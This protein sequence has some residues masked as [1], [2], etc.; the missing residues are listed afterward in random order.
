MT[1]EEFETRF[2]AHQSRLTVMATHFP[3][4]KREAYLS[5]LAQSYEYV[6]YSTRILALTAGKFPIDKNAF[7]TRFI[8][9][10]AEERGHDRLL[11]NDANFLDHHLPELPV[12]PEAEAFHKSLYFWI[13]QDN[14]MVILGW[15]F[16]LEG[17]AVLNA[18]GIYERVVA[19]HGKRAASFLHVHSAEDPDHLEKAFAAVR[20]LAPAD[21][22]DISQGLDL[23]ARL[24]ENIYTAIETSIEDFETEAA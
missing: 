4:E 21:L 11:V 5:W 19:A 1:F 14:P 18:P 3:W 15:V 9:H 17:F 23:Y 16:C 6:R 2:Q 7:S 8:Q 10:A 20:S 12:L 24:Y 22:L 13:F